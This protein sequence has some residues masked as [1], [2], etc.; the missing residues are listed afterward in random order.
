MGSGHFLVAAVD[1][2][3]ARF[4]NY[5]A[6]RSLPQVTGE[7]NHL[8]QAAKEELGESSDF[9]PEFEDNALLRRLIA[10][11]C[12][13]GVDI[14]EVAVQLSRLA[15]WIHT[16]VPGLP[17]SLLDRNL[18]HG[19]SLIGVG[20]ISEI[21]EKIKEEGSSY[22]FFEASAADFVGDARD[23]LTR[24]GRLADATNAELKAARKAWADADKATSPAKALCDVLTAARIEGTVIPFD[25]TH[26]GG[27]ARIQYTEEKS[28]NMLLSPER[29]ECSSFPGSFS[30]S[31]PERP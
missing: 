18:V 10:R 20:Q 23:A 19:N 22:S 11:R 29:N 5:L 28:T 3:E 13:Y 2:I 9:Y 8:R 7:L 21:E 16:F 15:L 17:L 6:K 31:V 26:W 25:F 12:I 1:R 4:S 27:R 24:L 30:G 14:N